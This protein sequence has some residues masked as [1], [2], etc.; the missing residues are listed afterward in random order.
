MSNSVIVYDDEYQ[1]AATTLLRY[2]NML[3]ERIERYSSCLQT[4]TSNAIQ[5]PLIAPRLLELANRTAA[6]AVPLEQSVNRACSL[7]GDFVRAID[8]A[9]CF[10][11]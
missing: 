5:D 7:C 4:I 11:A 9:D 6:L 1:A 8:E 2:G 10:L 3:I